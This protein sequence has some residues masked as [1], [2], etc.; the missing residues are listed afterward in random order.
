MQKTY[1]DANALRSRKE[2]LFKFASYF[3]QPP[4]LDTILKTS[5][6]PGAQDA[7]PRSCYDKLQSSYK[8]VPRFN[9]YWRYYFHF[10]WKWRFYKFDPLSS[11]GT[12]AAPAPLP[13]KGHMPHISNFG[14]PSPKDDPHQVWLKSAYWFRRRRW[15]CVF[16]SLAPSPK[17][18]PLQGPQIRPS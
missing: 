15:K 14:S 6:S 2:Y 3:F 9:I 4:P 13:S 18:S 10:I 7:H 1:L 17:L 11:W 5:S 16:A 12:P 8:N